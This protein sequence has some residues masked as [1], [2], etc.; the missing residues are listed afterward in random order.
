MS[1]LLEKA[2][3][4]L[5]PTAYSNG[6][7]H[8]V[9]PATGENI[10]VQSNQFDTTWSLLNLNTPTGG[11]TGYDFS[12]NAW[13]ITINNDVF[14]RISQA[15]NLNGVHT[16]S[17]YA[18]KAEWDFIG[19]Y[20]HGVN[21]GVVISL[22]DGSVQNP[23]IN[24]PDF[25]AAAED[26]GN[27]WFRIS[28]SH[29]LNG[30]GEF[31]IYPC[32]TNTYNGNTTQDQG[33]YIQNAQLQRGYKAT[34]YT[35]T[36]TSAAL[37][38]DFSFTRGTAATRVNSQGLIKD[39]QILSGELVQNGD[40]EQIGSE[41][42][43]NGNFDTDSDWTLSEGATITDN[44]V[45]IVS[46]GTY[47]RAT[48]NNVFTVGKQ[49]KLQYE[50][51]ENNSGNLKVQTSL[52]VD[53]IP[54]SV[55]THTVNGQALQTYLTI[56]R[57]GACDIT[58]TNISV[59]EVGQNWSSY[60]GNVIFKQGSVQIDTNGTAYTEFRAGN[61]FNSPDAILTIGNKY[62]LTYTISE[63]NSGEIKTNSLIANDTI[64]TSTVGTHTIEGLATVTSLGILRNG[65]TN[66]TITNISVIEITD[67]TNL[68][69]IDYLGGTGHILLEPQSTNTATYSNDFTQ[70]DI[71]NSSN[72]PF[73]VDAILTANQGTA[74]DGTNT[75][76]LLKD[77]NDGGSGQTGLSYYNTFVNAN[78]FNTF[79][80]F[81][82]KS[83][84]N[85]FIFLSSG[86]YETEANVHVY[87]NIQ[88]GT[89]G[90]TNNHS[91]SMED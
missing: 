35:D 9:K 7:L 81:V 74:P 84:S 61:D 62:R 29:P 31:R 38:G 33:V 12:S 78:D 69:R 86:G 20:F 21:K 42:V 91:A 54:S 40:F 8:S 63:S 34:P 23:I 76:F 13:K 75:A 68:P 6:M 25:Y 52:G 67:N 11:F 49:Y 89:L 3:I 73:L 15:F 48:Q 90:T 45:R 47:Q 57:S 85:N 2:S 60:D 83:L 26:V 27:G 19:L 28:I 55:G 82:K 32:E 1:N 56:E 65:D 46:D 5:T 24:Y 72:N 70:G 66:I 22:L 17:I 79:S 10:L 36:T 53:P 44:G 58:I 4:V 80:V 88:D 64:L 51:T 43:T 77:D 87:F 41:L 50:I 71:F 59:K 14:S 39:V 30:S 37:N 18:K 16:A